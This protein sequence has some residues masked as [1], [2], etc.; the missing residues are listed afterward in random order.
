MM[1]RDGRVRS[2]ERT[3][4]MTPHRFVHARRLER[5]RL[6]IANGSDPLRTA[7]AYGFTHARHFQAAYSRH[8][9]LPPGRRVEEMLSSSMIGV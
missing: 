2:F 4:H 9:G 6:A 1:L 8:H 5:I 3:F 7:A